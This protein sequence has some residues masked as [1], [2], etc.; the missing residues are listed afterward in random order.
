MSDTWH[1]EIYEL[2]FFV[3]NPENAMVNC[4]YMSDAVAMR[5]NPKARLAMKLANKKHGLYIQL[6]QVSR[7]I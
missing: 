3:N 1:N 6:E 2:S 7:I 4:V 5:G